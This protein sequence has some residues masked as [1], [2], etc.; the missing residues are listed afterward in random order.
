MIGVVVHSHIDYCNALLVSLLKYLIHEL[1]MVQN[2]AARVLCRIGEY[3]HTTPTL[4]SPVWLPVEF[5][6]K[7]NTCQLTDSIHGQGPEYISEML[8]LSIIQYGIRSQDEIRLVVPRTKRNTLGDRTFRVA[9]PKLWNSLPKDMRCCNDV[10]V[11]KSKFNSI[12]V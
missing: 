3:G 5:R 2:T 7:Y 11:L 12:L 4:K 6:I 1:Q 10:G 9:A 8:V